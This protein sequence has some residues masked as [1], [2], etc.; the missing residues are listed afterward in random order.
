V[1]YAALLA[2]ILVAAWRVSLVERPVAV[3]LTAGAAAWLALNAGGATSRRLG[4]AL[5]GWVAVEGAFFLASRRGADR[6]RQLVGPALRDV[7]VTPSPGDPTCL[8]VVAI[9]AINDRYVIASGVAA[10]F[11]RLREVASCRIDGVA[12]GGTPMLPGSPSLRWTSSWQG[13]IAELRGLA[14]SKCEVGAALRFIRIPIWRPLDGG[15]TRISD[16]RYGEGP[17]SFASVDAPARPAR[18]PRFVPPWVPPRQDLL[19]S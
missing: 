5:T 13:S 19:T 14:T 11:S 8:R 15:G 12:L 18:C 9:T 10:P 7:V 1:L 2:V 3:A 6:V 17:G 16:V 4:L